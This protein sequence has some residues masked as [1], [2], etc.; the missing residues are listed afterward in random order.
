VIGAG[1]ELRTV[2]ALL[3]GLHEPRASHLALLESLAGVEALAHA[4][5]AALEARYLWHEFGD[6]HLLLPHA[7][8]APD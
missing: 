8:R 3:T 1:R 4:Y 7:S 2:D 6:L 5:E